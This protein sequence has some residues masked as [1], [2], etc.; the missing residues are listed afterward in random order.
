MVAECVLAGPAAGGNGHRKRR[1]LQ[2]AGPGEVEIG[3]IGRDPPAVG[4]LEG[5]G[6]V[7]TLL[8]GTTRQHLHFD[9]LLPPGDL[10]ELLSRLGLERD[11]RLHRDRQFAIA[12]REGLAEHHRDVQDQAT[13]HDVGRADQANRGGGE[14]QRHRLGIVPGVEVAVAGA[15]KP[16]GTGN[17][18]GR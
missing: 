15:G 11:R 1:R 8:G 10:K 2:V 18:G 14:G 9:C 13:A 3:A 7:D 5:Q 17:I 16:I 12:A 6:A 4:D